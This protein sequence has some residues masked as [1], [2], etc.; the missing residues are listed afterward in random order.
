MGITIARAVAKGAVLWLITILVFTIAL[1]LAYCIPSSWVVEHARASADYNEADLHGMVASD[2]STYASESTTT[3]MV[4]MA[5]HGGENPLQ[6]AMRGAYFKDMETGPIATLRDEIETESNWTYPWYWHGWMVVLRP[7]LVVTDYGGIKHLL[8]V[9]FLV[10]AVA[11]TAAL[12]R[13]SALF[14]GLLCAAFALTGV[15]AID[16]LP[17]SFPSLVALAGSLF[18]CRFCRGKTWDAARSGLLVG[19]FVIGAL[20][21]YFDFLI[22]PALTYIL[23]TAFFVLAERESAGESCSTLALVGRCALLGVVWCVGYG[24]VWIGK[25]IVASIVLGENVFAQGLDQVLFRTGVDSSAGNGITAPVNEIDGVAITPVNAILANVRALAPGRVMLGLL[26]ALAVLAV[27]ACVLS[28]RKPQFKYMLCLLIAGA[29][30]YLWYAI[31]SNHSMIHCY[32]T[33]RL[34]IGTL[35]AFA[36]VLAI[37]VQSMRAARN[38]CD[39]GRTSRKA[40][41]S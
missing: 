3:I 20:T 2:Q 32:F 36:S 34:P 27:V 16:C 6:D 35:F 37:F 19:Y 21:C 17:Y 29:L 31:V 30:P 24:G 13:R 4:S 28:I 12:P 40:V 23:P 5:A 41:K 15:N 38:G 25:W 8:W 9:A 33:F 18:V 1:V 10:M 14:V 22:T 26:C 39:E 7:L 11:L